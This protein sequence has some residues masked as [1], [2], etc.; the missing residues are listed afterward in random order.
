MS[1]RVLAEDWE[2][3]GE[4]DDETAVEVSVRDGIAPHAEVYPTE[5]ENLDQ[6]GEDSQCRARLIANAPRLYRSLELAVEALRILACVEPPYGSTL[7]ELGRKL[8][9]L[10][11]QNHAALLVEIRNGALPGASAAMAANAKR[12]ETDHLGSQV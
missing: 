10:H 5:G 3:S 9:G 6:W 11:I 1:A 8:C 12:G 7:A 2:L 4:F